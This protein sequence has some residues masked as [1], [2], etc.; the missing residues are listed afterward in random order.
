[1]E[2]ITKEVGG[3]VHEPME[4]MVCDVPQSAVGVV[5]E[6][7]GPRK[8]RMTEMQSIGSD[9]VRLNFRVPVRGLVGFRNEF[10]TITRGEGIM[11]SQFDGYEPW[12]GKVAKRANGAIVSDREGETVAYALF[13]IQERGELFYGPG[14][15]VYEGMSCGE[16]AHPN[17]LDV[18]VTRGR[19]LTNV[20]AAGRDE[21]IRC[22]ACH[23]RV[24]WLVLT[25]MHPAQ[26][27]V[28]LWR[29]ERCVSCGDS[30]IVP[31][32]LGRPEPPRG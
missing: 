6:R 18:N 3:Q 11:S 32:A 16:H 1:P 7:L 23:R 21:S 15:A 2:P 24:G 5:T 26:W 9:R 25:G 28:Q 30:G 31:S 4:L 19:K 14:V 22:P 10:L 20:R 27:L 17:D 12:Q 29:G 13:D 8:G